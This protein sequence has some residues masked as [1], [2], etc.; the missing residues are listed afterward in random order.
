MK[1]LLHPFTNLHLEKEALT[2]RSCGAPNNERLEWLGDAIL[3]QQISQL[4]YQRF[5]KMNEGGLSRIRAR[6]VDRKTQAALARRLRLG[7]KMRLGAAGMHG[8][9]SNDKMLAGAMEAYLAAVHLDGGDVRAMLAAL[10]E[11]RIARLAVQIQ[12]AGVASLGN[13][14]TQLQ[15]FLQGRGQ[16]L[17]VYD[18]LEQRR[19]G[20]AP[21]FVVA[22]RVKSG[23]QAQGCGMSRVAAEKQAAADCL[24][25]LLAAPPAR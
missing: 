20:V 24:A 13:A 3:Q 10:L 6:L 7:D 17:P 15:E 4:L 19:G 11:G 16:P 5:P 14:K 8:G 23:V 2:H 18:V 12:Q 1:P 9:R 21:T 22:C 25:Q